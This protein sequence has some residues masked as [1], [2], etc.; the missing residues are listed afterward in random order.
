MEDT[1]LNLLPQLGP[2][3]IVSIAAM[4]FFYQLIKTRKNGKNGNGDI[5]KTLEKIQSN[6]LETID[7][8]QDR[9]EDKLD[10]IIILLVKI[11]AKLS[12]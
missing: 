4:W 10:Q 1:I 9:L 6:H 2:V 5:M 11:E 8:K 3:A 7:K 12:K